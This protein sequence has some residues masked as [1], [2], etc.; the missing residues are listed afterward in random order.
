MNDT[1][2][3]S[4]V[5]IIFSILSR[6]LDGII[7]AS[8]RSRDYY[9]KYLSKTKHNFIIQS[10]VDVNYFTP[11]NYIIYD[12]IINRAI[13]NKKVIVGMIANVSPVKDIFT[14]A[15]AIKNLHIHSNNFDVIIIG[16]INKNQKKY[17][18]QINSYLYQ[19]KISNFYFLKSKEDV[20]PF[21]NSIDIYICSSLSESSPLSVWEA[22]SMQ[23][24]II[25]T[26]VGDV[27]KFITNGYNGYIID[28]G[29]YLSLSKRIETLMLNK[30]LRIEFGKLAREVAKNE[31]NSK[32]CVSLH[33]RAYKKILN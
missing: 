1:H 22:M 6:N 29:D 20:R 24:A 13:K 11:G 2:A 18:E 3:P 12:N 17:Y 9:C 30:N 33:Q 23:K 19:N 7:F 10:P 32:K 8:S 5:R 31:L 15:K 26:N 21:L 16:A 4:F 25:S 27:S 14:L 28:V